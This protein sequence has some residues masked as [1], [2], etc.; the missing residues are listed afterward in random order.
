MNTIDLQTFIKVLSLLLFL[1]LSVNLWTGPHGEDIYH[2]LSRDGA[3]LV[4]PIST[5]AQH[6]VYLSVQEIVFFFSFLQL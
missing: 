6:K 3:N 4:A 1:Q 5:T 2:D